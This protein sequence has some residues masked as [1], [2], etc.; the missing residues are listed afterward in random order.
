MPIHFSPEPANGTVLVSAG[1]TKLANHRNPLSDQGI[2]LSTLQ[3]V[4]PHAVYDL[5]AADLAAG[6]DLSTA[7]RTA[8][9]YL[10]QSNGSSVAAAELQLNA[11]GGATL[12]TNFN[13]GPFVS[14][15]A[16]AVTRL[17]S[18]ANVS[19]G[20]YE[21]R[22][23]RFSAIAFMAVW[24]KSDSN[25]ADIIYPLA[26]APPPLQA[27]QPYSAG[28]LITAIRPLAAKRAASQ[29]PAAP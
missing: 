6:G 24:L 15:T 21:V 12:L 5:H 17:S 14:E 28:D 16:N 23:L 1:L 3:A 8:V 20:S 18:L 9:R 22:L 11:L 2:N 19:A 7:T 26:P 27:A 4:Q 25:A 10:I 29:A 13:Y